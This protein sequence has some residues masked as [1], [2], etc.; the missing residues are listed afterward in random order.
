MTLSKKRSHADSAVNFAVTL[1]ALCQSVVAM[2]AC[3]VQDNTV[4]Q[5]LD[6]DG[7]LTLGTEEK[8]VDWEAM[9]KAELARDDHKQANGGRPPLTDP[10][11]ADKDSLLR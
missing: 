2:K 5:L 10:V 11:H 4:L 8:D 7:M 9:W 3:D 1:T 6:R